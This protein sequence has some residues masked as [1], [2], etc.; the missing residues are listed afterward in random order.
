MHTSHQQEEAPQSVAV[1][2]QFIAPEQQGA[3]VA[4][5]FPVPGGV[6][7]LH[8][9]IAVHTK[10][11]E[12]ATV[13][14]GIQDAQRVRGWSGGARREVDLSEQWATPGYGIGPLMAGEWAVLLGAYK[15]P[16][17]GCTVTV[18]IRME[19]SHRRWIKGDLHMH[20]V[21]SDGRYTPAETAGIAQE[22]GLDFIALTDHNTFSQNLAL[23]ASEKL[24]VIPGMEWTTARGHAN[25]LGVVDPLDDWRA[26]GAKEFAQRVEQARGRGAKIS[27]N[28]PH[29]TSCLACDWGW[30]YDFGPYWL[31]VWNGPWRP[32]NQKALE[33]WHAQL[34]E[35]RRIVAVGGSDTHGPH[36]YVQHGRPTTWVYAVQRSVPAVLEAIDAGHA[37]MS[38]DPKGPVMELAA[39]EWMM[40]DCAPMASAKSVALAVSHCHAGDI[41]R[42]VSDRGTEWEQPTR[43]PARCLRESRDMTGR[44][45]CRGEV[46]RYFAEVQQT[47]MVGLTN[48]LYFDEA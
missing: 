41:V 2:E 22:I 4:V 25:L 20:T 15:I 3:V 21:H 5:K 38:F 45:F 43:D 36:P 48:P 26:P 7:V 47:L 6:E 9:S 42:L 17:H 18:S 14:L 19:L 30:D 16:A 32:E 29:D 40:G 11:S 10:E 28:H 31:E 33:W 34:C 27:I 37:F 44:R 24:L 46:W 13:D 1:L 35:G 8:I 39:G 12:T 23:P